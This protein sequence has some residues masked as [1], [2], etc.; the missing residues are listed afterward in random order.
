[1]VLQL[2]EENQSGLHSLRAFTAKKKSFLNDNKM[3]WLILLARLD[4][5]QIGPITIGLD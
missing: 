1:M 2:K 4:I 3:A 5:G